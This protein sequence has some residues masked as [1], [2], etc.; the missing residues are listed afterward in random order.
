MLYSVQPGASGELTP[1]K[2]KSPPKSTEQAENT[3]KTDEASKAGAE[4]RQPTQ[5]SVVAWSARSGAYIPTPVAYDGGLYMV[6][7]NGVFVRLTLETGEESFKKRVKTSGADFTVSPW[8]YNGK[9]F[10]ASEQGNIFVFEAGEEFNLLHTIEV[11]EMAMASPA[12]VGDRLLFRTE[13]RII[14]IRKS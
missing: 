1:P 7:D 5:E 14:S 11:G 2:K 9:V 10:L 13:K 12:I 8:A 4:D 6:S 3:D